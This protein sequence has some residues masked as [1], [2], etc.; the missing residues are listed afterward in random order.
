MSVRTSSPARGRKGVVPPVAVLETPLSPTSS[1]IAWGGALLYG[2]SGFACLAL[3]TLWLK[4]VALRTGSTATAAA[5]VLGFFFLAAAGG[6]VL[7]ARLA[8]N[9]PRPLRLYGVFEISAGAA[10]ALLLPLSRHVW[11]AESGSSLALAAVASLAL[12]GLPSFLAGAS[13]PLLMR[14]PLGTRPGRVSH[15][16]WCYGMN[17][18]GAAVGIV[19]GGVLL[20]AELGIPTS[21]RI[22]AGVQIAGGLVALALAGRAVARKPNV[23]VA[24][25]HAPAA[26]R[27][28]IAWLALGASGFLALGAQVFVMTWARQLWESSVFAMAGML[29]VFLLGLGLGAFLV[30][31][32][33]H[34]GVAAARIIQVAAAA[35]ALLLAFVP[36]LGEYGVGR[37]LD[38]NGTSVAA[39]LA[40]ALGAS[41]ALLPLTLALGCVF[42]AA[43]D[44][45]PRNG[46]AATLLGRA[47]ALNKVA[48]AAGAVTA[49]LA[50]LPLLGLAR[51]VL[52][53]AAGYL[54]LAVVATPRGTARSR[55]VLLALAAVIGCELLRHPVPA[56]VRSDEKVLATAT[57]VYGPV[58]VVENQETRS[59]QILLNSRQRLSGTQ[60]ALLAQWH[61]AWVPM[62]LA[63]RPDEVLWI[64]MAAGI[65]ADAVL[66]FPVRHLHAV[67]LVPE[68]AA[69]A[70][71]QF[72][73]W[74]S[75]LF[76]DP[77]AHVA[78]GDGRIV[79][80]RSARRWSVIV[81]DLLFPSDEG[82]ANLYSADFLE[83][84]A[85]KLAPDGLYCLWL[86][87]YQHTPRSAA[88]VIASFRR[89][90][91]HALL[92]RANL[93]PLQPVF[94]LVGSPSPLALSKRALA[95]RLVGAAPRLRERSP[96]AAPDAFWL[97]VAGDLH[98]AAPAFVDA[99]TTDDHPRL[100][101]LGPLAGAARDRLD[102]MP[103]LQWM[104]A[105]FLRA[106]YPSCRL[107]VDLAPAD[108]N[109]AARAA[110][111]Y[112]AASVAATVLPHDTRPDHVRQ[113]Q[114]G[115]QWRQARALY[116]SVDLPTSAL[117]R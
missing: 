109:R 15:A 30:A 32:L 31:A 69:A 94:G 10:A 76:A 99:E 16:G 107:E 78:L 49:G 67:E 43:W 112:Y 105:R 35:A 68:V 114:V 4:E 55:G 98:A 84:A 85:R 93:D 72:A 62:L 77:R 20:P 64:G 52:V 66:D 101:Y 103:L 86:P 61:Q 59:R 40:A 6:N 80:E 88:A 89:A 42:P 83:I 8:C 117:G 36:R 11:Q 37:E 60:R 23:P 74:N 7:G 29:A 96:Y 19:F 18:L 108:L 26:P 12:L 38:L 71:A 92:V 39:M 97:L 95:E 102:G 87:L 54:A 73:P 115:N 116:P 100:A 104:G 82:A 27:P 45:L 53:L 79:L 9:A 48:A 22:A 17:L 44:L 1:A 75:R 2:I 50:L 56:G 110:N 41:L 70:R 21:I 113:Q 47:V 34:R 51:G 28:G 58:T 63:P 81:C 46:P 65:S 3:E 24:A 57:G 13:L 33:R 111:H 5:F 90:F 14:I 25:V 91:P 106:E